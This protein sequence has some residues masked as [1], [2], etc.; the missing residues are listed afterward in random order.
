MLLYYKMSKELARVRHDVCSRH[1]A[2]LLLPFE[3]EW[4]SCQDVEGVLV[5]TETNQLT[6]MRTLCLW[7]EEK[8]EMSLKYK[9]QS[10]GSKMYVDSVVCAEKGVDVSPT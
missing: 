9:Q 7:E 1:V 2:L 6:E 10:F 8:E 3:R 5:E 4:A